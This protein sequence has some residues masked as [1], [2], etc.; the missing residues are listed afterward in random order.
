VIAPSVEGVPGG[1]AVFD[2]TSDQGPKSDGNGVGKL[3]GAGELFR[4]ALVPLLRD[5]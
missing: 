5:T 4:L 3:P 1:S 2:T